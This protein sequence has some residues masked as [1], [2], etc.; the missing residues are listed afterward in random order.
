MI[1]TITPTNKATTTDKPNAFNAT[2]KM[3]IGKRATSTG[4]SSLLSSLPNSS[5]AIGTKC[6]PL[7]FT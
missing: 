5:P 7:D 4:G 3:I 1:A 6:S 2:I